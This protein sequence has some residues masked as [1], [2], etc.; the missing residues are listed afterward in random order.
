MYLTLPDLMANRHWRRLVK[1]IWG[2]T[3]ILGKGK[4]W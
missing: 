2:K 1:N 3:K 4:R